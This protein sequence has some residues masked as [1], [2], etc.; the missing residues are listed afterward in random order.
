MENTWIL[1]ANASQ[2]TLY[3]LVSHES[4]KQKLELEVVE[5]FNHPDS[6]KKDVDLVSDRSGEYQSK[7]GT[8]S[9]SFTERTDPHQH[10]AAV[11][12]RDLIQFIEKGRTANKFKTL[13]LVAGPHFMGLLRKCIDEHQ[14]SKI[15]IHEVLK[16]YIQEKPQELLKLLKLSH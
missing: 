9:G 4:S 6:R 1:V 3:N 13:F 16:E 2:A 11:F 12:A 7:G 10:E 14:L 8:G 5:Q 15:T